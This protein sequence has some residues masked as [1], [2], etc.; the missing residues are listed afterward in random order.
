MVKSCKAPIVCQRFI[1]EFAV[2]NYIV[3]YIC[4]EFI[5]LFISMHF[6]NM[7]YTGQLIRKFT[8]F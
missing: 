4:F 1:K 2:L 7:K 6:F 8:L 3:S 5:K